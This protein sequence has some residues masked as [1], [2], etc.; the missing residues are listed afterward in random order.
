MDELLPNEY[1]VDLTTIGQGAAVELFAAE[2]K[3]VID[4]IA[5]I[6][7]DAKAR[8]KVTL[9]ITLLPSEDRRAS[10]VYVDCKAKLAPHRGEETTIF[11]GIVD[12]KRAAVES[13]PTQGKLFDKPGRTV[14][15]LTKEK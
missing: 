14:T 5:D 2:W 12:G 6:N 13:N 4:N 11:F 10:L 8:R 9:E 15:P 3:R 1:V 7:T